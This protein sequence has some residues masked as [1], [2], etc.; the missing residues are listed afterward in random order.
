MK[1]ALSKE[2]SPNNPFSKLIVS[3]INFAGPIMDSNWVYD[4]ETDPENPFLW[5]NINHDENSIIVNGTET[6]KYEF[7]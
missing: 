2:F 3:K 4:N 1:K 5:E 6:E 7:A